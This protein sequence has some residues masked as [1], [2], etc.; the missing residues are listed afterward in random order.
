[1]SITIYNNSV[2]TYFYIITYNNS[3]SC[4]NTG[5]GNVNMVTN[6]YICIMISNNCSSYISAKWI[7][8]PPLVSKK[9]SPILIHPSFLR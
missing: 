4:P 7:I 2:S 5:R 1:M 8:S 6:C 9:L 3:I